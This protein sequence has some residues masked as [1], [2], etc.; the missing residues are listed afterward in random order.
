MIFH[1]IND[2]NFEAL[3]HTTQDWKFEVLKPT[4]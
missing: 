4:T 1:L 2:Q 3:E